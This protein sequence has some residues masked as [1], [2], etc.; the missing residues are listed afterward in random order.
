MLNYLV[1][2]I[3]PLTILVIIL[4]GIKEKKDVFK[5]FID[6]VINRLKSSV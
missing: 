3:V 6:G 4:I 2:S 5:L 1:I